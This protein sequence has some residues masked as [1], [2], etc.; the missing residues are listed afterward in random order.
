[1]MEETGTRFVEA[2]LLGSCETSRIID[3]DRG[4]MRINVS[5]DRY[6]GVYFAGGFFCDS[7]E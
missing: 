7:R 2:S 6:I 5:E 1:M 4:Q 3:Q